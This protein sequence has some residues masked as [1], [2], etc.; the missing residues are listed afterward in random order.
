MARNRVGLATRQRIIDATRTL[1]AQS[2][3]DGVTLKAITEAAQV[4]AGSFYNLF[5]SKE[6]VVFEVV[7]DAIEAVDPDPLGAGAESLDDLV[8]AFVA[9]VVDDAA[10]AKIYLQLAVGQGVI[11]GAIADRVVRAHQRRL[12]RFTLACLREMPHVPAVAA[13]QWCEHLLAGLTGWGISAVLDPKVDLEASAKA[14]VAQLRHGVQPHAGDP[15][16]KMER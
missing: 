6:A 14:L 13:R 11:D 10:V 9:F 1:L 15:V 7:R 16:A 4:G 2:S 8:A 5:S 12:D 3:L